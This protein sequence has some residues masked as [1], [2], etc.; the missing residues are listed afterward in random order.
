MI[1]ILLLLLPFTLLSQDPELPVGWK[2][3]VIRLLQADV[4]D[5]APGG[6]VG[7]VQ[8]GRVLLETYAGL[9]D[10]DSSRRIGPDTRFNIASNAKQ[11]TALCVL[12]LIKEGKLSL[13]DDVRSFIPTFLPD[14]E[15]TIRINHLLTHTSGVR[16]VYNLWSLKGITWWEEVLANRDAIALLEQ[17]QSLNFAPGTDYQYSNSNYLLLA[18][19]VTEVG[20][21]PFHE[22]ASEVFDKLGMSSTS[23]FPDH[24]DTIPQLARPYFNFDSWQTY[25][26]LTELQGD[27]AL[28]TTLPDQLNYE[29]ALH[30]TPPRL[31]SA[32]RRSLVSSQQ[33]IRSLPGSYAFGLEHGNYRGIPLIYHNGSTGAWKSTVLRFPEVSLSILVMNNSGKFFAA[34]L[35]YAIADV[36]WGSRMTG[37][38]Y[39]TVPG[40]TET[41]A[42]FDQLPGIYG[43]ETNRPMRISDTSDGLEMTR[44]GRPDV[45]L[46]PVRAGVYRQSTDTTFY[47][48]FETDAKGRVSITLYHGSH[49]P[50]Q[51]AQTEALSET[52]TTRTVPAGLYFNAE[53]GVTIRLERDG[54]ERPS[55]AINGDE[56][57]LEEFTASTWV[58]Q[59][60]TLRQKVDADGTPVLF[61]FDDRLQWVRFDLVSS[62]KG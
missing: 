44:Y 9:A 31:D 18:E 41:P 52:A 8:N 43:G 22:Y 60:F 57:D 5:G 1:R 16:D 17:Q 23:F 53:I 40:S 25:E 33:H 21:K 50:Y 54:Q 27:G 19:I 47:Q 45:L 56:Q 36:I 59:R 7:I 3:E 39:A 29:I 51:L 46:E 15:D 38:H 37:Q 61:L 20:G 49:A 26:W 30:K 34:D 4:P 58:T 42:G 11:F 62:Y 55:V 14:L 6:A 28:F 48:V 13:D 12:K 2:T 24:T 10:L 35:A 32:M